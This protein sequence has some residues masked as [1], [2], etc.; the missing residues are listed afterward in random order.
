MTF[1]TIGLVLNFI[2]VLYL[3]VENHD[4]IDDKVEVYNYAGR[5][6]AELYNE[7]KEIKTS[8]KKIKKENDRK[9]K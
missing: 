3:L 6:E 9:S 2:L 4:R 8:I 7:I 1:I 5:I